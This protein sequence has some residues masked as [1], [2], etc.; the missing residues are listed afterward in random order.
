MQ[1]V[2][3]NFAC[4]VIRDIYRFQYVFKLRLSQ[5]NQRFQLIK[6]LIQLTLRPYPSQY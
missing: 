4:K 5:I 2:P 3:F 6:N 1:E